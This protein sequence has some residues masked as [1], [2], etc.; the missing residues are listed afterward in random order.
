MHAFE[1]NPL[2][3]DFNLKRGN[4]G[5]GLDP[6]YRQMEIKDLKTLLNNVWKWRI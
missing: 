3:F 4:E 1:S 2:S 6:L 5:Y